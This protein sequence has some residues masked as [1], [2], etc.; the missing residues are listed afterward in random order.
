MSWFAHVGKLSYAE[1]LIHK[2]FETHPKHFHFVTL[3]EGCLTFCWRRLWAQKFL[4]AGR[5]I[6]Y[7]V[8]F[9]T[10]QWFPKWSRHHFFECWRNPWGTHEIFDATD[11]WFCKSSCAF[12][13][14][15]HGHVFFNNIQPLRPFH[16]PWYLLLP[17]L[18]HHRC[19]YPPMAWAPQTPEQ[20]LPCSEVQLLFRWHSSSFLPE[21]SK[22]QYRYLGSANCE[23]PVTQT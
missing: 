14:T 22:A 15:K 5:P 4:S 16:R 2:T 20:A 13:W 23:H 21:I 1:K 8:L 17:L 3:V 6:R 7:S 9:S 12:F 11:L 18:H 10:S 19:R